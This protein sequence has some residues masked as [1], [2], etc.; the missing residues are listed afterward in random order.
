MKALFIALIAIASQAQAAEITHIVASSK[1][2]QAN[3]TVASVRT[4]LGL[5]LNADVLNNGPRRGHRASN[6]GCQLVNPGVADANGRYC[7][8]GHGV[9]FNGYILNNTCYN[10]IDDAFNAMRSARVCNEPSTYGSCVLAQP[11]QSDRA[12]RFCSE[13]YSVMLQGYI[14]NDTCFNNAD[15]ALAKMQSTTACSYSL[16]LGSCRVLQPKEGDTNGRFCSAGYG[17]AYRGAIMNDTCYNDVDD[18]VS[19]M[20][21]SQVCNYA[22]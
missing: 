13:G 1:A 9:M 6:F 22:R 3:T 7:S 20:Y 14:V 16:Q 12:E 21:A 15:D 10:N 19:N 2:P 11:K 17:I 4:S 18:A 5:D 8:T